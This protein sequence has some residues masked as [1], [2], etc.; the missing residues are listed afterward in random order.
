MYNSIKNALAAA[1]ARLAAS[2][3][4]LRAMM[5]SIHNVFVAV[6][7]RISTL[8][9]PWRLV[10]VVAVFAIVVLGLVWLLDKI[11]I[12]LVAR[13][14]VQEIV[15]VFDL[16]K[17]LAIAIAWAVFAAIIILTRFVFSFS[18]LRRRA[19]LVSRFRS[20]HHYAARSFTNFGIEG[21]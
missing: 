12:F 10:I 1:G 19:G 16:N 7:V 3:V 2:T 18:K 5:G 9:H 15:D 4:R 21:H 20:S 14:Y 17:Y 13:S 8:S 11:L 6:R